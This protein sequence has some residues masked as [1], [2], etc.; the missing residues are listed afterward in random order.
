MLHKF[1]PSRM[2]QSGNWIRTNKDLKVDIILTKIT[3]WPYITYRLYGPI[4]SVNAGLNGYYC[5]CTSNV[6]LVHL[7]LV[8]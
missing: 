5:R 2:N 8:F 1:P 6:R 3:T 4:I 7:R